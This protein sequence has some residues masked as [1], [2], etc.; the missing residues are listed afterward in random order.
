MITGN[1][2]SRVV[3]YWNPRLPKF[4][5]I[6]DFYHGA[7][8]FRLRHEFGLDQIKRAYQILSTSSETRQVILQIWK[9][10]ID[11]PAIDGQPV[12]EDIP[13][14]V[15]ALLKIRNGGLHWSQIMRSNDVMKG[16]PYNIIQFTLLQELLAGWLGIEIGDYI[17]FSDSFH[18]YGNDLSKFSC[19]PIES[20]STV[21]EHF[22][23]S[24]DESNSLFTRLYDDLADV[25]KGKKSEEE[26]REIFD[27]E[28]RRNMGRCEFVKDMMS[29][30]G[31]DAARRQH[32]MN[33]AHYLVDSCGDLN[34]K[35]A[36]HAWLKFWEVKNEHNQNE[37]CFY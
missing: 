26:L 7:Y 30:I 27:R 15:M 16:L 19:V 13:C 25:S 3:N 36:S 9:P 1:K 4:A 18:V 33:L 28:S 14:N 31:S 5:G 17:H 24:Y 21:N 22:T 23:M 11:L 10:E 37:K 34:L 29:V 35:I 2:E 6:G 20:K 32:H 8:G 12:S